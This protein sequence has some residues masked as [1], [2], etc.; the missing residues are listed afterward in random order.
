M[1]EKR[2]NVAVKYK[3]NVFCMLYRNKKNLLELYNALNNSNYTN[4]DDLQV[5]T[6]NGGS[7][8]KY[9]ND[10]SF[11]LNM[12]LY[13]FEQQSSRNDNMPLRFLHYLSD[14]YREMFSNDLLHRRTM[15]KIPVPYFV[16]FY[17]G[18][19]KWNDD[20]L[21]LA[22]MFE[23]NV[24]NPKV[25]LKVDV[26]DINGDAEILN[27]CTS[28]RGYMT[29]VEKVRHKTDVEKLDVKEAVTEAMD[30]C[31]DEDILVDFFEEHRE[32]VVEVSIYDY[33]EEKVRKTLADEAREEGIEQGETLA[34]IAIIIKK[35]K[36][37][38]SFP[39][40]AAELEEE[41]ADIKPIYDAVISSAPDYDIEEIKEKLHL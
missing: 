6:L 13:M 19:E 4:V 38:K 25:N 31:I 20:E 22:K 33:D 16:T 23:R 21:T 17:N 37:S 27:K 1:A 28:L 35:V 10:A 32:E 5:T 8:M 3:D 41:E 26:I 29:F 18:R 9:K 39:T 40:I 36:K 7:Y 2:D 14:V 24:E 11:V 15:I 30:E 12:S 34:K